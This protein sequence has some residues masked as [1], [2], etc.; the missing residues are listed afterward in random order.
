[1]LKRSLIPCVVMIFSL[2][3]GM[4]LSATCVW[5]CRNDIEGQFSNFYNPGHPPEMHCII[6]SPQRTGYNYNDMA[7]GDEFT[8]VEQVDYQAYEEAACLENCWVANGPVVAQD[9]AS[10]LGTEDY[11]EY[12]A[13]TSPTGTCVWSE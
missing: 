12:G 11:Q 7:A 10:N 4:Q 9:A 3:S 1:M 13:G 8:V 6:F 5:I 2:W